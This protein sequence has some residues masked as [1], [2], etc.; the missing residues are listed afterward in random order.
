MTC[1][2]RQC[3][4]ASSP[5]LLHTVQM[6]VYIQLGNASGGIENAGIVGVVPFS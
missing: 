5:N 1:A 3:T 4:A 6:H 2:H